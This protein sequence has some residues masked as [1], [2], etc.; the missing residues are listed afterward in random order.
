MKDTLGSL[1]IEPVDKRRL[2][3]F[4]FLEFRFF[5]NSE[6]GK[7]IVFGP[8]RLFKI[9]I[10]VPYMLAS[11][12]GNFRRKKYFVK[13]KNQTAAI[14][15]LRIE[16]D[17]LF[18]SGLAVSPHYRRLG[19]GSFILKWIENLCK[20]MKLEWLELVVLKG[21]TPAQHLYQKF[22]FKIVTERKMAL[23]LRKRIQI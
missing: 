2:L 11:E 22:G 14:F 17:S 18:V 5:W 23:T 7:A 1:R 13:L 6:N 12:V 19:V 16:R 4:N 21:N 10:V 9:L 20:Q 15:I 3:T 8:P